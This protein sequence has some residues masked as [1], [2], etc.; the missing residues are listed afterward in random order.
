MP[1]KQA[2]YHMRNSSA[3]NSSHHRNTNGGH[4]NE[5]NLICR[6]D[7]HHQDVRG[8]EVSAFGMPTL[9]L[10]FVNKNYTSKDKRT[11]TLSFYKQARGIII[12]FDVTREKSFHNVYGRMES[13]QEH[14]W[15][16]VATILDSDK[17]DMEY[18]EV[19]AKENINIDHAFENLMEQATGPRFGGSAETAALCA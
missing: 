1:D 5:V 2:I 3:L 13:I 8:E 9:D 15:A 18:Y 11:P 6:Q 14:G 19:S 10:D 12:T 16:N 17:C 7:L 4:A